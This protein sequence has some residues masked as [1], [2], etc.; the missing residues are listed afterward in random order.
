MI[1][2]RSILSL[3]HRSFAAWRHN[4]SGS[5]AIVFALSLTILGG[6]VAA[7][8][9]YGSIV[10]ARSKLQAAADAAALAGAQELSLADAK[11]ENV[12]AVVAA[13]VTAYFKGNVSDDG[14]AAAS[15]TTTIFDNPLQVEVKLSLDVELQFAKLIGQE[16][17]KLEIASTARVMG[18]PNICIL[19]L[20]ASASG[21]I[22]LDKNSNVLGNGCAVYSNSVSVNSIK[23]KNSSVLT[24]DVI[25][26]AGGKDGEKGNFN[27]DPI[28]DCPTFT[29]PLAGRSEP[30]AGSCTYKDTVIA[31]RSTSLAP[32]VYCGGLTITSFANVTMAAGLYVIK[33]GP[34]IVSGGGELRGSGVSIY[35]TGQG[36]V[37]DTTSDSTLALS[38]MTTGSTAGLLF[39]ESRGQSTQGRH[40]LLSNNAARLVGTVYLSRGRLAIGGSAKVGSESAYTAIVARMLEVTGGPQVVLNTNYD[41]TD[42][43][44]P[45][46]IKGAGQPV[47]IAK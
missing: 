46:G 5:I 11:R 12:P 16:S 29:D 20:D 10:R 14:V 19:G 15:S 18:K 43:P 39:F 17:I 41:R 4:N 35:L 28:T 24:A 37:L 27:P 30:S 26:A 21:T 31:G 8:V 22:S 38:A 32:G 42:V 36:A 25:C 9:D 1:I 33:D 34:L 6:A 40:N 47:A 13:F 45:D 7:S 23:S 44:V 3:R 2:S